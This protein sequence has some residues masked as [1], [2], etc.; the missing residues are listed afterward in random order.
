MKLVGDFV[1][2]TYFA[3]NSYPNMVGFGYEGK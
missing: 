1:A 2:F 3:V